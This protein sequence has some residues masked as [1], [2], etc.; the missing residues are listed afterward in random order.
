MPTDQVPSPSPAEAPLAPPAE[1]FKL[2]DGQIDML[3][4][5]SRWRDLQAVFNGN[6]YSE[7]EYP[8]L[9]AEAVELTRILRKTNTG[10][11]KAKAPGK[12]ATKKADSQARMRA[13]LDD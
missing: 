6:S 10:P 2:P 4:V 7:E 3:A 13:L 11:A 9:C 12:R 1:R 5:Q 8:T